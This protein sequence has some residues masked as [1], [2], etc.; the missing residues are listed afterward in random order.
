MINKSITHC[1]NW[2]Y[3]CLMTLICNFSINTYCQI[4]NSHPLDSLVNRWDQTIPGNFSGQSNVVFDSIEI[5]HFFDK[6]PDIIT[7]KEQIKSF[8]KK[9]NY[10]YAWFDDNKLIEQAGNLS[11]RLMNLQNEGIYK[12]IFYQ[13]AL[14]SLFYGVNS[15]LKQKRSDIT[16]ELMLTS[17]YFIFSKLVWEGMNTAVSKSA[18]WYLPRKKVAYDEYL[19][20]VLKASDKQSSLN[21]PVYRQYELLKKYLKKYRA[22]NLEE[23]WEPIPTAKQLLK[24]G[25]SSFVI[26]KIKRRLYKLEDFQGDTSNYKYDSKLTTAIK[27]FQD[28]HGL[29]NNGM[30]DKETYAELNVPLKN[31][32]KQILVNMERSRWLPVSLTMDYLAVN[33]PE[34]RLHVY[35]ADSLLWS[36]NVVVGQAIHQTTLFYGEIK[37][38]VFS[39]YWNVPSSIVL[40][41][42]MP[43]IKKDP[44]YIGKHDMEVIGNQNG[45]PIV[46]QKPGPTNSLGLVKFMFPNNY[47]IYLH[48]TPSKSLFG[49]T[50]RAFSHGCIRIVEP[51]KLAN[52]LLKNSPEWDAVKIDKAMH[53][54]KEDYVTLNSP[55]PVFIAY[56]TAFTDRNNHLNFRKDIYNLDGHLA[57][58]LMSGQ[59]AY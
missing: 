17:Q 10:A 8:Y 59:G 43:G 32:I 11:N 23:K 38:I 45:L 39:P 47:N 30:L 7:Y 33:I 1:F 9:R 44:N 31:R 3:V 54:G 48:D 5:V 25:D 2:R 14:D 21:E 28:R 15:K 53:T 56:F 35:H 4:R 41:E 42:I 40:N 46:R 49:K 34:F 19:D 24:P 55:V 12:P 37:Y 51:V 20:S 16:L 29:K 18:K 22:L 50:S 57:A 26:A 36:C 6:F 13:K 27:S 58:M 52:F